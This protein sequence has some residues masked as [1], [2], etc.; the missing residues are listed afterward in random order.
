L[1]ECST[2]PSSALPYFESIR[3][4]KLTTQPR[5]KWQR[6]EEIYHRKTGRHIPGFHATSKVKRQ[7]EPLDNFMEGSIWTGA[8]TIGTPP[9]S[10]AVI[11]DTGSGDL[12]VAG[13]NVQSNHQFDPAK[14][15]TSRKQKGTF[16]SQSNIST[17][18]VP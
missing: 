10:F 13:K 1:A 6:N 7:A 4:A 18:N 2:K 12:W 5:S 15:S 3:V 16:S 9:Q 11:P 8:I 17:T 14:S